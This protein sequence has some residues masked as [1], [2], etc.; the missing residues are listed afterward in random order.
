MPALAHHIMLKLRD[1]RVIAPTVEARRRLARSVLLR[2]DE[3]GLLAFRAADS[4]VHLLAL[5]DREAAGEYGRRVEL[6]L[7][8]PSPFLPAHVKPIGDQRY[9]ETC[10]DYILDQERH[11][12]IDLDP[13]HEASA[14]PDLLGLRVVAPQIMHRVRSYLPRIKRRALLEHLGAPDL[15]GPP[16]SWHGLAEA[17]AAALGLPSLSGRSADQVAARVAAVHATAALGP[18]ATARLLG[19]SRM[20]VHRL[21]RREPRPD[22]IRALLRQLRLRSVSP[23]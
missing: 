9:L 5:C 3:F 7:R 1:R 4:H 22:L 6:S 10:F 12:E 8:Q 13:R 18:S 2:G 21:R 23:P 14:L 20:T 19:T 15:D 11:H 16:V 17:S